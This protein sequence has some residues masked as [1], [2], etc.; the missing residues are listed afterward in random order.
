LRDLGHEPRALTFGN[1]ASKDFNQ[2]LLFVKRPLVC[3]LKNIRESRHGETSS[4]EYAITGSSHIIRR[5]GAGNPTNKG[6][7]SPKRRR[8]VAC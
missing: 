4:S 8:T 2:A 3:R 7:V 6:N 1:P 5:M